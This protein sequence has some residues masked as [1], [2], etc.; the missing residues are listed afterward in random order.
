MSMTN[1]LCYAKL[2]IEEIETN[3]S[4]GVTTDEETASLAVGEV[5]E[6]HDQLPDYTGSYVITPLAYQAQTLATKNKSMTEDLTVLEIPLYEVTN[7]YGTTI[8]IG[9]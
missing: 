7:E 6:V 4:L 8:N 2:T 5:L 9:G 3:I 1:C